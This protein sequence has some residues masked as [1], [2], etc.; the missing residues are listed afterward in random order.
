MLATVVMGN[1][2]APF[3]IG[4]TQMCCGG[5]YSFHG[6]LYFTLDTNIINLSVKQEDIKYPFLGLWYE[7]TWNWTLVS[8][9]I[10]KNFLKFW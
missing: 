6:L 7:S 8:G 5:Q 1:P 4:T 2:K 3:L 10:G 9:A